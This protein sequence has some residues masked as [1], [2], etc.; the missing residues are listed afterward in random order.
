M[1]MAVGKLVLKI[2]YA[3][4]VVIIHL[5]TNI[6]KDTSHKHSPF[7]QTTLARD[8]MTTNS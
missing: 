7:K 6:S 1:I 4:A 2:K 5:Q 8:N 3:K